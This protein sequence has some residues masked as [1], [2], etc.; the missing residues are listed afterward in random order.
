MSTTLDRV[1]ST[2]LLRD[3]VPR[4]AGELQKIDGQAW[5]SADEGN[6]YAPLLRRADGL[7][8]CFSCPT[9]DNPKLISAHPA[10]SRSA[11]GNSYGSDHK[12]SCSL[13]RPLAAVAADI[14]RRVI[15]PATAEWPTIQEKLE[16]DRL[17]QV[18]YRR[19]VEQLE[20]LMGIKP[21]GWSHDRR[22][23]AVDSGSEVEIGWSWSDPYKQGQIQRRV[24]LGV[25]VSRFGEFKL[26]VD[27][28]HIPDSVRLQLLH[29]VLHACKPPA[30]TEVE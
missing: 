2:D 19:Q 1:K 5:N 27:L 26:S 25:K 22:M 3:Y 23:Q 9:Y 14:H 30:D 24:R 16:K 10:R 17:H 13:D 8:I 4:L 7:T 12:A 18:A 11:F 20:E 15:K 29:A 28:D 21:E 6:D